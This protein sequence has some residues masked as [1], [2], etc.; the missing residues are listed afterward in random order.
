MFLRKEGCPITDGLGTYTGNAWISSARWRE[1]PPVSPSTIPSAHHTFP[2]LWICLIMRSQIEIR[3]GTPGCKWGRQKEGG[4]GD[5][6][7]ILKYEINQEKVVP[8]ELNNDYI[9]R[10]GAEDKIHKGLGEALPIH[11]TKYQ[12][13]VLSVCSRGTINALWKRASCHTVAVWN[14]L[15]L[16]CQSTKQSLF[17]VK[18]WSIRITHLTEWLAVQVRCLDNMRSFIVMV[19]ELHLDFYLASISF[20]NCMAPRRSI[21][22]LWYHFNSVTCGLCGLGYLSNP[23]LVNHSKQFVDLGVLLHLIW[24]L[25]LYSVKF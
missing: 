20:P 6:E 24:L 15:Y 16:L 12:I 21:I 18:Q 3:H 14:C 10:R 19:F 8:S 17:Y 7:V 5:N 22:K 4:G 2:F 25:L 1:S 23:F 11:I 9:E 13:V